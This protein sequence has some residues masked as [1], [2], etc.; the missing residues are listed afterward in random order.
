V[1]RAQTLPDLLH[2]QAATNPD[3][4]ALGVDGADHLSYRQW[5]ERSSA[6]ALG[7]RDADIAYGE[8]V[9]LLFSESRWVDYAVACL[10]VYKAGGV[11]AVPLSL[12]LKEA[13]LHQAFALSRGRLAVA[14]SGLP[15]D[16][17]DGRVRH[18]DELMRR[19][20]TAEISTFPVH[21][22][23]LAD[24]LYTSGTTGQPKGIACSH[25]NVLAASRGRAGPAYSAPSRL[26][27]AHSFPI[28]SSANQDLLRESLQGRLSPLILPVFD[29][30]RLCRLISS[31]QVRGMSL[32]PAM[33][34]L[35]LAVIEE[36]SYDVTPLRFVGL[37]G[38]PVSA[39]VLSRLATAFPK[40]R[41]VNSYA[42]TEG[43]PA[44]ALSM[45]YDPN[46]PRAVGRLGK[47]V[48]VRIVD[49]DS[50]ELGAGQTGEVWLRRLDIPFRHYVDDDA[51]T[52]QV[53][54]DGWLRTG[55][56]GYVDDES[57]L[58]IVDRK[59]DIVVTGGSNV[60]AVEVEEVLHQHPAVAEA[61]V[62]GVPHPVLGEQVAAAVVLHAPTSVGELQRH[63]RKRL[64]EFKVPNHIAIFERLPRT[65][66]GKVRKA[67]LRDEL[68][69]LRGEPVTAPA[70]TETEARM[71]LIWQRVFRRAE[72]GVHDDFFDLGG[73]SLLAFLLA[74]SIGYEFS[75]G[76][77]FAEL[78][79]Q[80]T[81]ENVA[82][83]VDGR[84]SADQAD[85]S[86]RSGKETG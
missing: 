29:P 46:R 75:V 70:R 35:L 81:V 59:K 20:A 86:Q 49:D 13:E 9:P 39:D 31:G 38:A 34:S 12:Q 33:A 28:G 76:I 61:A 19:Q 84:A 3:A 1:L 30:R 41:V 5:D 37:T 2:G 79:E 52:A 42:L 43:G 78:L 67:Q 72:V 74:E 47:R 44:L 80:G 68:P 64:A 54:G 69:R 10:G 51:S 40:A 58:Y 62:V 50:R 25:A 24:I 4:I 18:L 23:A 7:L 56:I 11:V 22:E 15:L 60:S 55:D 53:F 66:S 14:E 77:T 17:Y 48:Q 21:P 6:V 36:E 27:L 26:I 45:R 73:H 32:V 16:G 63:V 83:L 65:P 71:I 57:Y 82:R 8:R 85:G